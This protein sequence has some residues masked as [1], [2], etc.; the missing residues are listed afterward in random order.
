MF[1]ANGGSH[2]HTHGP[3]QKCNHSHGGAGG[4]GGGGHSHGGGG[5]LAGLL[6]P[7]RSN[8]GFGDDDDSYARPIKAN[9][10]MM[11]MKQMHQGGASVPGVGNP[12]M[13]MMNMPGMPPMSPQM[14][15]FAKRMFDQRQQIMREFQE[16]GGNSN[17]DAV[18]KLMAESQKMQQLAMAEM[19]KIQESPA[20]STS[21]YVP[22][23]NPPVSEMNGIDRVA[24][25]PI[26]SVARTVNSGEPGGGKSNLDEM[27]EKK[28]REN[29]LREE[30]EKRI[31]AAIEIKDFSQLSVV[32]ATQYGVLDRVREAVEG[33]GYDPNKPDD[34]NVYLL[35]W[36]AINNRVE[37]ADYLLKQGAHVDPVGG[38]LESTPLNWAARSGHVNMVA[39]LIRH[40][41]NPVLYDIEGF[42]TLHLAAMFSHS[43][44]VAYLLVKG[45]DV[46]L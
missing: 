36:A 42:S 11:A 2:G 32:K 33:Q 14:V 5:G 12:M 34:E 20:A 25:P 21:S 28:N 17:P 37:I 35:H 45:V 1:G 13:A 8:V 7:N 26:P 39:F 46:R 38:E 6:N 24:V 31:L 9:P 15:E 22:P 41:A 40:G 43:N 44:V 4:G 19:K 23:S 16:A 18:K 10:V 3:G 27:L 30:E 29:F